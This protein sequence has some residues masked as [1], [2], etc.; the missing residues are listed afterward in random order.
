MHN[1]EDIK[2]LSMVLCGI[3]ITKVFS[4]ARVAKGCE[5]AEL[6]PGDS[7]DLRTGYDLSDPQTQARAVRRVSETKPK[8][9]IGGPPCTVF[10][11]L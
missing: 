8:F 7:F 4:P 10:P 3:D 6:I 9:L 2:I 5:R 11:G 1:A